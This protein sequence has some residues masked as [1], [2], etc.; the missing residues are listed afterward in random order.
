[1]YYYKKSNRKSNKNYVKNAL[2]K[3]KRCFS[4][5]TWLSVCTCHFEFRKQIF[6]FFAVFTIVTSRT[7]VYV[8]YVQLWNSDHKKLPHKPWINKGKWISS[9]FWSLSEWQLLSCT[10]VVKAL[11]DSTSNTLP[12]ELKGMMICLCFAMPFWKK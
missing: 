1:M 6:R 4:N 8:V 3:L 11:T 7:Y 12:K 9:D 10:F 5:Q 2:K